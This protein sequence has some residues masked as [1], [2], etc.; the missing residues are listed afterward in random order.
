MIVSKEH[1][2]GNV[3]D[4]YEKLLLEEGVK[5]QRFFMKG[6]GF[7]LSMKMTEFRS[8]IDYNEPL[9]YIAPMSIHDAPFVLQSDRIIVKAE[10]QARANELVYA[11]ISKHGI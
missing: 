11:F 5:A 4:L 2:I 6:R 9:L 7:I 10:T 8:H 3:H 1:E